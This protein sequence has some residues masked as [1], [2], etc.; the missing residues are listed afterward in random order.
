MSVE[1]SEPPRSR[2]CNNTLGGGV[3]ERDRVRV[4]VYDAESQLTL[5]LEV[6]HTTE[7]LRR[8]RPSLP[9]YL[10]PSPTALPSV[11]DL[12]ARPQR[13]GEIPNSSPAGQRS[14]GVPRA[15]LGVRARFR[16]FEFSQRERGRETLPTRD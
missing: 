16:Y 5:L 2:G 6:R 3:R 11:C 1:A 15:R 10:P 12:A 13:G 7:A 4:S 8:T 14:A 9:L